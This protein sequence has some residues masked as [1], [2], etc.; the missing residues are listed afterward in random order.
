M[1]TIQ[2]TSPLFSIITILSLTLFSCSKAKNEK[3]T[4]V[5]DCT[6]SYLRFNNKDYRVC[7]FE[8]VASFNNGAE[9]E[10][11]F[12]KIET[13]SDS[14]NGVLICCWLAHEDEGWIKVE[15]IK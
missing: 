8:S 12:K 5:K 15:K 7:N 1:K 10:A 11:S 14:G 13:C 6:G 9:V 2:K 3:M 4:V